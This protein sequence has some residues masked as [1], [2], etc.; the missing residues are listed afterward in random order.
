M[1]GGFYSWDGVKRIRIGFT[2]TQIGMTNKQAVAVEDLLRKLNP[3]GGL[4]RH[5]DCTGADYD[6]HCIVRR[7]GGWAICTHP[8]TEARK[9]AWCVADFKWPTRPYL[10][11]NRDIVDNSDR[12]VA[13]PK[14]QTEE[15]RSGTWSTIRYTRKQGK[16][17]Y[18]VWPD[19][20]VICYCHRLL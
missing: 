17:L 15:L 4:F 20:Q 3:T 6:A 16:P 5:G 1:T 12:M 7:L 2:G 18:I 11:R 8:P 10:V 13:C 9:R 14:G 19:G